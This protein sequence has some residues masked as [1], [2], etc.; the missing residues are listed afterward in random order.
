ML[1]SSLAPDLPAG[2]TCRIDLNPSPE[3]TFSGKAELSFK[4]AQRCVLVIA[5]QPSREAALGRVKYRAEFFVSEWS[6]R[7]HTGNTGFSEL[8]V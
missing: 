1:N 2:W 5:Q 6:S 4:G 3:G 8:G 7:P